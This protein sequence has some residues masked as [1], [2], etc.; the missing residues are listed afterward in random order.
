[1]N[2]V[3]TGGGTG[4]HVYPALAL[5]DAFAH[6]ADFTPLTTLFVGTRGRLEARIVPRAGIPIAYVRA[7]PL[8]RDAPLAI[9]KT[10]T[11]NAVGFVESLWVL[12]RARPDVL[13]ATGGYVAFPVVAAL[14]SMRTLGLSQARIAL[15]EPNVTAGLTNRLLAPLV[16]EIWYAEPPDDRALGPREHVVGMPVRAS[17]RRPMASAEARRAL[18]LEPDKTTIVVFGGSL[19]ARSLNETAA[20]LSESGLPAGL[21][22]LVIAGE[23][24]FLWLRGRLRER[25]HTYVLEYLE[26]PRAAYAAADVVIARAGASTLGELA[27][28]GVPALLVPYPH[29]TADHQTRNAR[30]FAAAGSAR[31]LAD[32]DL[33]APRLR[34]EIELMLA[35]LPAL[36]A[37]AERRA[38]TDPRAA[39]VARVKRW[40]SPNRREP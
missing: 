6:E 3:L 31:V 23:R 22:L 32:A 10:V 15:L 14:R 29:A 17:M 27:A 30:A 1:V 34:S 18:G 37:A 2:L 21:Q 19:G 25:P 4:G 28:V 5:A 8:A 7:A 16:D 33:A 11:V 40:F 39:I 24:D 20:A 36:R 26:D 12:R 38:A 35:E 9:V 13:I